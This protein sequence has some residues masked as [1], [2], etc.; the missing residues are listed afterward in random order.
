MNRWLLCLLI[1]LSS[2]LLSAQSIDQSDTLSRFYLSNYFEFID[3]D[4]DK[5]QVPLDGAEVDM[6]PYRDGDKFGFIDKLTEQIII[7]PQYQQVHCVHKEGAVVKSENGYGMVDKNNK[8]IIPLQFRQLTKTNGMYTGLLS[9]V[10]KNIK[11]EMYNSIMLSMHFNNEGRGLFV[12]KSHDFKLFQQADTLAWFRYGRE[13]HIRSK[14]GALMKTFKYN[15]QESFI[16]ICN[17]LLIYKERNDEQKAKYSAM[18]INGKTIFDI[19]LDAHGIAGIY[20]LSDSLFGYYGEDG[21]FFFANRNGIDKPY[22]IVSS[23]VGFFSHN[24]DFFASNRYV[25]KDFETDKRGIVN[26][27]GEVVVPFTYSIL[28]QI[29]EDIYLCDHGRLINSAGKQ[30]YTFQYSHKSLE[31]IS[32]SNQSFLPSNGLFLA[33]DYKRHTST[34]KQGKTSHYVVSG[35]FEFYY[36]DTNG[37]VKCK[38]PEGTKFAAQF[39]E[40]L[41]AFVDSTGLLGFIDTTGKIIIAPEYELSMA[42][43]Y[44]MPYVITPT[45]INGYAYIKSHKGYINRKG[46][47]YF[48][49]KRLEDHYNFSH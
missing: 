39:S 37:N 13:Y 18:D 48:T 42:G 49:G 20:Q 19:V 46:K 15:E 28:H 2:Q 8:A 40:G 41:A 25:A 33:Q 26:R 27:N 32:Y 3:K 35:E 38:A 36:A 11:E 34:D 16:G 6:I 7:K 31:F 12:E 1:M 17:N 9:I 4:F 5:T 29:D 14:T 47:K 44:P 22:G 24:G 23:S 45:F 43:A 21:D 30:L 10:D